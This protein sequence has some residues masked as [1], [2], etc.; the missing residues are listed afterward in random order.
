MFLTQLEREDIVCDAPSLDKSR[1]L[2]IHNF[3]DDWFHSICQEFRYDFI[4]GCEHR[5][6]TPIIQNIQEVIHFQNH[7]YNSIHSI[8]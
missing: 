4:G 8:D 3:R 5:Q 1:L 6:V 7:L 2:L